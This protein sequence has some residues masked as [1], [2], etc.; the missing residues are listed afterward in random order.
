MNMLN[1]FHIRETLNFLNDADSSTDTKKYQFFLLFL[2]PSGLSSKKWGYDFF[3]WG[4][5]HPNYHVRPQKKIV[6]EGDDI[7]K[8]TRTLQLLD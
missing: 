1:K 8:H 2:G 7:Q 5:G 6:R 3:F 4:G